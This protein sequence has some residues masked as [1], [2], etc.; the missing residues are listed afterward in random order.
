MSLRST[1]SPMSVDR[2][3]DT[4]IVIEPT[5]RDV[6]A[7][8]AMLSLRVAS[9]SELVESEQ[10]LRASIIKPTD[11][12]LARFNRRLSIP[13]SVALIRW[14]AFSP[15]AMSVFLIA[16]GL[17]TG[18]LFSRGSYV[19]GVLAAFLSWT[20]SILDGCDGELARLQYRESAFGT[21]LDTLG[22]YSYYVA[23][24]IGLTIGVARQTGSPLAW[25]IGGA[26]MI[27]T[28]LTVAFL[29]LL[30][31]RITRG[32]PERLNTTTRAH[33][34]ATGKRWAH[35]VA[36]LS[37]VATRSTMPYG[38][39]GLAIVNLLP[40][41][42]VLAAIGAQVYWISLAVEFRRLVDRSRALVQESVEPAF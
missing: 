7:G 35:V 28:A 33:F 5:G 4:E 42:L 9:R 27:G 22:D 1:M 34:Y 29:I 38:V 37:T 8:R 13:I 30:R 15:H 39:L 20:G 23:M 19:T 12:V 14:M 3:S 6:A 32:H 16:L 40:L 17:Y 18:W 36:K 24:F 21:W 31:K 25:W 10:R 2:A 26:L 11:G 41:V